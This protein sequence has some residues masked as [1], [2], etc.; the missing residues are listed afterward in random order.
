M[1][2]LQIKSYAW[3]LLLVVLCGI[4]LSCESKIVDTSKKD[5]TKDAIENKIDSILSN[6]SLEEKI[7]QTAQRGKSSRVIELPKDL[8]EAVR[9]GQ[10]G[11][12]LNIMNKEDAK[13]LQRLAVEESPSKIPLIFARD[14]I[15]GFKTIFPIPLG[16]AASFNPILV[17]E[18]SRI[19]AIEASTSG[20]RWTFAPMLDISRDPRWG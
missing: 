9:K 12:F 11:S 20:I 5:V 15:H 2:F 1:A 18:G 13:E 8:K 10:I 4:F 7:G 6:M 19:A 16:Q 14:V 17:E 3:Q